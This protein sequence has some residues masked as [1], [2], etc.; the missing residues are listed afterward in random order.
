[1]P[2]GH[3]ELAGMVAV[4]A[5]QRLTDIITDHVANFLSAVYPFQQVSSHPSGRN[6]GHMFMLRNGLNLF[7]GQAAQAM[8]SSSV[9]TTT[10]LFASSDRR[11]QTP[12]VEELTASNANENSSGTVPSLAGTTRQRQPKARQKRSVI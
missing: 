3:E 8:Q 12:P 5:F 9:I 2:K 10:S 7:L 1:M 6:L 4:V 11:Y